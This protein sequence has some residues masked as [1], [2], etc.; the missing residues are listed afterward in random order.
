[1]AQQQ[2]RPESVCRGTML[3]TARYKLVVRTS[4]D[5]E[6]YDMQA[7]PLERENLYRQ[8]GYEETV[9]ELERR[10]LVWLIGT[11]DAVPWEPHGRTE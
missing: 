10:M 6:L 8:A 2:E 7:D 1:M 5:N 9:R 4:G 3:R 11:S